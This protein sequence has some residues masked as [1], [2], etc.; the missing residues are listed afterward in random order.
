MGPLIIDF[1]HYYTIPRNILYQNL[2][3]YNVSITELHREQLSQ[4][5]AYY[6]SRVGTP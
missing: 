1:K 6:L 2:D 3:H 4:R 5:F